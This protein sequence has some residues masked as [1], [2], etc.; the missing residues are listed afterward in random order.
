MS[1]SSFSAGATI[2]SI[3]T[4]RLGLLSA[5]RVAIADDDMRHAGRADVPWRLRRRRRR[6]AHR[7]ERCGDALARD[8]VQL[9]G[10]DV[11]VG[12]D[13]CDQHTRPPDASGR[14]RVVHGLPSLVRTRSGSEGLRRSRT[15]SA[16]GAPL[17]RVQLDTNCMRHGPSAS[18]RSKRAD[19]RL[20]PARSLLRPSAYSMPPRERA[21]ARGHVFDKSTHTAEEA[22]RPSA[23]RSDRS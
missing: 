22:A 7:S 12:D 13:D 9:A 4:A 23:R 6:R 2:T 11:A 8:A 21:S 17:S 16:S 5:E 14:R 1:L 15:L 18:K 19:A 20:A 3:P 10:T